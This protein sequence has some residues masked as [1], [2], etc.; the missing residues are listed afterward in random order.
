V[1]RIAPSAEAA[2]DE[3]ADLN[4]PIDSARGRRRRVHHAPINYRLLAPPTQLETCVSAYSRPARGAPLSLYLSLRPCLSA[5]PRLE[6][7]LL[8]EAAAA[9]LVV[10][11]TPVTSRL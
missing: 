11:C 1:P 3:P 2:D 6:S 7:L 8:A 5:L 10:T 4:H 9:R